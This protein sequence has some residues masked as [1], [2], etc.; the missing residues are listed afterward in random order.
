MATQSTAEN[1]MNESTSVAASE[2]LMQQL[3]Q[4]II[5]QQQRLAHLERAMVSGTTT[6]RTVT[7]IAKQ[8]SKT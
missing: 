8:A 6:S 2:Q 7:S 3:Q 1:K 5:E 4:V